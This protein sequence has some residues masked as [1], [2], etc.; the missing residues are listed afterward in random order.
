MKRFIPLLFVAFPA[1]GQTADPIQAFINDLTAESVAHEHMLNSLRPF[2]QTVQNNMAKA[3]AEKQ[4]LIEWLK[5]A[6][7]KEAK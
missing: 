4:Q 2:L 5:E 1:F 6:Q 7:A 3:E